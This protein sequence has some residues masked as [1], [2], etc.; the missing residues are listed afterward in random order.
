M[1]DS[2]KTLLTSISINYD[3]EIGPK[4]W[5]LVEICKSIASIIKEMYPVITDI[6]I[7]STNHIVNRRGISISPY[8]AMVNKDLINAYSF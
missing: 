3:S 7:N 4:T 2:A 6:L 1:I 8:G 5:K